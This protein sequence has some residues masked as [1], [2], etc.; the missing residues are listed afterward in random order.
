MFELAQ[1]K[2]KIYAQSD[3]VP[4]EYRDNIGNVLIAQNMAA[5][6]G[7]DTLMVMQNL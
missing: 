4:K 3:L 6:M 5:R 2:A 7:A 1:R